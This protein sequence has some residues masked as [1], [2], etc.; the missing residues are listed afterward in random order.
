MKMKIEIKIK[1]G[2]LTV[3]FVIYIVFKIVLWKMM[4]VYYIKRP[5]EEDNEA[6]R[7]SWYLKEY[8][9]LLNYPT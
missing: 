2:V 8:E 7:S 1:I 4:S 3:I 9:I 6:G 5:N